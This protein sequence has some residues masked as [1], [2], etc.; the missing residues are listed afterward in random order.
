MSFLSDLFTNTTN[1]TSNNTST[2]TTPAALQPLQDATAGSLQSTI[3]NPTAAV[4]PL[5]ASARTS[6]NN[7][8]AGVD[9]MLRDRFLGS[10]AGGGSGKFGLQDS[11]A[12]LQRLRDLSGLHSQF[13][14]MA[15]SQQNNALS[16]SQ[17]L[18]AGQSG[19][20][21]TGSG[22]SS[23]NGIGYGIGSLLGLTRLLS[24]GGGS[25]GSPGGG[26]GSPDT[27][28]YSDPSSPFYGMGG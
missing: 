5:E 17:R 14:Q 21:S 13:A 2:K 26:G 25:S 16:L 11:M 7:D 10:S 3:A 18:I 22:T 20:S 19:S 1:T 28:G 8:Y 24:P 12:Q 6:V 27:G 15:L 9:Q 4:A 23:Q